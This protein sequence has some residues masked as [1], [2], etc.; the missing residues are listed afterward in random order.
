MLGQL[1]Q[2][3]G[4]LLILVPF[5]LAQLGRL[6]A[7]SGPALLLNLAGSAILAA[8]AALGSQWGFLLLEG[9]W[10][11]VSA[12]GLVRRSRPGQEAPGTFTG[13]GRSA[14]PE[15]RRRQ[16][17]PGRRPGRPTT[18][19]GRDRARGPRGQTG[20]WPPRCR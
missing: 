1:A 18:I 4:S 11:V 6:D 17:R 3:A 19:P 8:D 20:W 2:I 5:G 13:A 10:A 16:P 15:R 14:T 9:A 7:R 12:I